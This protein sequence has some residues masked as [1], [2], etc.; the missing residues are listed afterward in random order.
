[1]VCIKSS[2]ETGLQD[3][4]EPLPSELL[5]SQSFTAVVPNQHVHHCGDRLVEL[6][7][8]PVVSDL[9]VTVNALQEF[10]TEV[11]DILFTLVEQLLNLFRLLATA[12]VFAAELTRL[13]LL[14]VVNGLCLSV[15]HDILVES[16]LGST[17]ILD[18]VVWLADWIVRCSGVAGDL[19]LL[20]LFVV[21]WVKHL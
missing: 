13:N 1:M 21:V 18:L 10:I 12:T 16:L 19:V 5:A 3:L 6:D 14:G 4:S 17:L 20:G 9:S 7:L 2:V 15:R 8:F 11:A